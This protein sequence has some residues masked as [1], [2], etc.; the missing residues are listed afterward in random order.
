MRFGVLGALG[1][2]SA[3]G[4][5]VAVGGPQ[6]RALLAMLL[7]NVGQTVGVP[8]L[9]EG[10]YGRQVPSGAAHALQSQVSRLRRRLGAAG[11]TGDLLQFGPAGY[12]L[13]VDPDDVDVH[14]FER[15]AGE[16]RHV[17]AAGDH[18]GAAR[19]LGEALGLW[20]GPPD[21]HTCPGPGRSRW[22]RR[23][24]SEGG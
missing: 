18:G 11:E 21:W 8:R 1:V 7:L 17:L 9:V 16:G 12:R 22:R 2:W 14:R 15:L 13:L 24:S 3:D 23:P 5:T 6:L 19:L 4:E 20:R 10:L